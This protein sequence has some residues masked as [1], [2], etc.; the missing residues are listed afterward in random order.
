MEQSVTTA[1]IDAEPI[2]DEFT[3]SR[4]R[5][6]IAVVVAIV[7]AVVALVTLL[8]GLDSLRD[9]FSGGEPAWLVL[10]AA[11]QV[12]SCA[13]YVIAFRTVF[14]QRMSWRT[15]A[16]IGLSELAA[17]SVL[18][19]GGAGGLA[20]GAWIL[21]RGGVSG[22]HIARRTVAFF[23]LT[24]L[25]N[26]GFL[27]L[28]GLGLLS[29]LLDG[30][31]SLLLGLIPALAG[32]LAIALAVASGPISRALARRTQ[33]ERLSTVLHTASDGV[34]EALMLL[35]TRQPQLAI[36]TAAY[37]LMDVAVLAACFRAFG[38]QVPPVGVLLVAY[39][40]GQLGSLIP[41]PG[42]IGG[43]DGGLIGALVLYG[44]NA[45]DAAVAVIAYRGILL[46]VPAVMGFPALA[47]LRRK[48][49]SE[50]HDIA[51]CAPGESVDVLGRGTVQKPQ[52][53]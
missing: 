43:V 10:A 26:V 7:I 31:S 1:E 45:P 9:R 8:P 30:P 12:L 32:S 3:P 16:Q 33:W 24:S 20:L 18:S 44:V 21:R 17:N 19:V 50:T 38:H 13:G 51:R 11:F 42:G 35:R 49:R 5:R 37:M 52:P 29:R 28:G 53:A 14:C 6:S 46:S 36:G 27:A 22:G 25:A 40:V 15:S 47:V 48:L 4:M 34:S 2:P 23:L 41:I 39:I